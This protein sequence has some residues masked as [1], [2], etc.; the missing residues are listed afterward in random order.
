MVEIKSESDA[1]QSMDDSTREE[2]LRLQTK[3]SKL[4]RKK[5]DLVEANSTRAQFRLSFLEDS[6]SD[7]ELYTGFPNHTVLMTFYHFIDPGEKGENLIPCS[8]ARTLS[9][10]IT[11]LSTLSLDNEFLLTMMKLRLGLYNQDLAFRFGVSLKST[12]DIFDTWTNLMHKKLQPIV[13]WPARTLV[14][15]HMPLSFKEN[16]PTT[17][18]IVEF[19]ELKMTYEAASVEDDFNYVE[20]TQCKGMVALLPSGHVALASG[21]YPLSLDEKTIVTCSELMKQTFDAGDTFMADRSTRIH[22]IMDVNLRIPPFFESDEKFKPQEARSM[23]TLHNDIIKAL[24]RIRSFL[25]LDRVLPSRSVTKIW[26]ICCRLV[27]CQMPVLV[28]KAEMIY[29]LSVD[30]NGATADA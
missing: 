13:L 20:R 11:R 17:R 9:N 22:T 4:E 10:G 25:I 23:E 26:D 6:D 27:N 5:A 12:V 1:L 24:D 28:K 19:V 16:F 14:D 21:L 2:Y 8:P 7:V 29:G 3:I 15:E 18:V 30:T